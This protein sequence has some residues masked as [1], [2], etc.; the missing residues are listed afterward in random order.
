MGQSTQITDLYDEVVIHVPGAASGVIK[1]ATEATLREFFV[2]SGAFTKELPPVS[3]RAN[4]ADY[5]LDPQPDGEILYI[6]A[7]AYPVGDRYKFL[8]PLTQQAARA[9]V[10]APSAIPLAFSSYVDYPGKFTLQPVVTEDLKHALVPFCAMTIKRGR[11]LEDDFQ[12]PVWMLRYWKDHF[13]SG[14]L[15]RLFSIPDKPYTNSIQ[16]QY[17]LRRFRAGMAQARDAARRQFT[18]AETPFTFPRW[19]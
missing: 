10:H 14:I 16:S 7:M 17:H 19:A 8:K 13:V 5:Y 3:I 18:D 15:G 9:R 6:H 1:L 12:I 11:C 2:V 4:V